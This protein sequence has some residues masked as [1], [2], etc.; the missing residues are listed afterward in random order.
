LSFGSADSRPGWR[1]ALGKFLWIGLTS[2]G[3]GRQAYLYEAFV[4][5]GWIP[6]QLFLADYAKTSVL[7]GASFVNLTFMC[8]WRLGGLPL[9]IAG[10]ALVFLPGAVAIFAAASVLIVDDP[11][12]AG[13]LH[14]ILVGAVALLITMTARMARGTLDSISSAVLAL[15][16]MALTLAQ[17]PLVVT[18]PLV[19]AIGIWWYRPARGGSDEPA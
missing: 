16:S 15:G 14:G 12:I 5:S 4:R 13:L 19:A 17:V 9:A 3:M 10:T 7:P 6:E 2:V 1:P 11:R 8:G 18:V